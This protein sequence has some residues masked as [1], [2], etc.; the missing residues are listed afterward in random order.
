VVRLRIDREDVDGSRKLLTS[1]R[2]QLSGEVEALRQLMAELRPPVLDEWGLPAALS[3]YAAQFE[4][5]AGIRCT[6]EVDLRGRL[7]AAHE[8]VLYRVAQEALTNV[9]KHSG[10]NTAQ[11]TLST[12]D[13]G[14]ELRITDDGVGFD[15]ASIPDLLHRDHYGL[16]GMRQRVEM[17]G[18]TCDVVSRPGQGT[19]VTVT[20]PR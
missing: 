8:T 3:A 19:T 6:V 20:L 2:E 5:H 14:V 1:L 7:D 10:A 4:R 18:G 11:I 15:V 13:G 16:A 12:R 17:A 9:R